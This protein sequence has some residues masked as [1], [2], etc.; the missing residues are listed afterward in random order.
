MN[1]RPFR[2]GQYSASSA[3]SQRHPEHQVS[4]AERLGCEGELLPDLFGDPEWSRAVARFDLTRRQAEVAGLVCRGCQD[5]EIARRLGL[6]L[7]GIRRHMRI[8][9]TALGV[10]HRI[11]IVV[12]L[13]LA[14]R[15]AAE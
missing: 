12:R 1:E 6:T 5:K 7:H 8:L 10:D 9:F 4:T 11:G 14:S 13:I 15:P 3:R 2:S